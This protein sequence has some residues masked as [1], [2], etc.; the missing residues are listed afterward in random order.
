M[1]QRRS[2]AIIS[3]RVCSLSRLS[4]P[5]PPL[6]HPAT[7]ANATS[8]PSVPSDATS[9]LATQSSQYHAATCADASTSASSACGP[10]AFSAA[11]SKPGGSTPVNASQVS[12]SLSA[13]SLTRGFSA[14]VPRHHAIQ[15]SINSSSPHMRATN[16]MLRGISPKMSPALT[17]A[18]QPSPSS[19]L[20]SPA[21]SLRSLHTS[22]ATSAPS[23]TPP[24]ANPAP[25]PAATA[26]TTSAT[27]PSPSAT[28]AAAAAAAGEHVLVAGGAAA[29]RA[30]GGWL[31]GCA[32]WVW[33]L[34][35]LGGITR[36]TRSGL[37]MTD[38]KFQGEQAPRSEEEWQ[39]E[40]DKYKQSPEFRRV[41]SK[42]D[43]D[44]FKFIYWM[45]YGHRMWGRALGLLFL[46]PAAY[47]AARGYIKTKLATRCAVLFGLGGAQGLIGWWM[48]KSG[49]EEP[50]NPH[51]VPRVSPYRLAAH[52]TSAFVIFSGIFWTA[53]NVL[54]PNPSAL[55]PAQL[56]AA[57]K[58]R[59]LVHPVAMLLGVTAFSGAFV[60][61]NDAG[62]AFNT[63][64]LMGDHWVPP[65]I[66]EMT[67]L[68]RNFFENTAMVQFQHRVLAI[69]T[70]AAVTGMWYS[71][72]KLP[73]HPRSALLL[74]T[75]LGITALQ[76][77]LGISA[78][79]TYV[80]VSLGSAHQAGALTLFAAMLALLH[81]LRRPN[82][83]AAAASATAVRAAAAAAKSG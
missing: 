52:L 18:L 63:F 70:L 44:E 47:F 42:M 17:A 28:S 38:W 11:Q 22:S 81:S 76:V 80:P 79:L 15:Q 2:A 57:A 1:W 82:P 74:N 45:E 64:P 40:F 4:L 26:A 56:L 55:A 29:E 83:S 16:S 25:T 5:R 19:S 46:F 34:V 41:N 8:F 78:L 54:Y 27:S 68:H 23:A 43:V 21:N 58:L 72:R 12:S 20:S 6:S 9:L 48:V 60:A 33:A 13:L 75:A 67:P 14:L 49:L 50:A 71:A 73:L 66:L 32:A 24:A 35:V 65:E 7:S 3:T 59:P 31:L 10:T 77:T 53:L 39:E 30:V 51:A 69:S 62:R 37:S 36:L 61:G